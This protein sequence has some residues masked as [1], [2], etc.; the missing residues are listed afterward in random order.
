MKVGIF[1]HLDRRDVPLDRYYADRLRL[2]ELYDR[3]GFYGYHVAEHHYTPL[4]LSPSPSVYLS[5]VAQR[6]RQLRFG[7]LVYTL[8]LYHPLRLAEE[9]CMLDQMGGGRLQV[10]VGRGISPI[11]VGYFGVAPDEAQAIYIEA[12]AVLMQALTQPSV[13]H[14][15]RHFSFDNVPMVLTPLQTPHP[16]LWYGVGNPEGVDWCVANR[17]NAVVNG[18]V[19]RVREITDRFRQRWSETGNAL[20]HMPLIGTNRHV[21]VAHTDAQAQAIARRAYA[22]WYTSFMHLWRMHGKAPQFGG[23]PEDFDQACAAGLVIAGS[24]ATVRDLL[25]EQMEQV[26]A[27]YLLARFAFGDLSLTESMVS[28]ELFAAEVKPALEQMETVAA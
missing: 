2:A 26:G 8:P 23:F 15:G 25:T 19:A 10:G 16:P 20:A 12:Y 24:P 11:E 1:D 5:A 21:V 13:N 6:T 3:L 7:P 4:G 9:I 27:T 28:A 17:I 18:P 14:R 22:R